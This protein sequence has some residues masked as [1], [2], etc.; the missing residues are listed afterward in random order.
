MTNKEHLQRIEQAASALAAAVNEA[1]ADDMAVKVDFLPITYMGGRVEV[2]PQVTC[3][4]NLAPVLLEDKA[5]CTNCRNWCWDFGCSKGIT[6][7]GTTPPAGFVCRLFARR[8]D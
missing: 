2:S 3:E 6:V 5:D 7:E 4:P 1:T 8:R